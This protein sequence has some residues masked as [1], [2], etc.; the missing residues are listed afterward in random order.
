[1]SKY[2][3][4]ARLADELGTT[5]DEAARLVD[6]GARGETI[7]TWAKGAAGVGGA[8]GGGALLWRQQDVWQ[9]EAD[10]DRAQSYEEAMNNIIQSDLA[11]E[12]K[13]EMARQAGQAARSSGGGNATEQAGDDPLGFLGDLIES[14]Q[15]LIVLVI[16][17]VVVMNAAGGD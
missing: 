15:T 14:P 2:S 12:Q 1:M 4:V 6:D 3:L 8:A 13:A 11:P 7:P 16:V 10:A 17:L 9:S 5:A